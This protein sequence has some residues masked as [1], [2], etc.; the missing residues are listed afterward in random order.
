MHML[1]DWRRFTSHRQLSDVQLRD[2]FDLETPLLNLSPHDL[3]TIRHACEGTQIFGTIG[4]GKTSGSGAAIARAYLKSGF[5]G[6][7]LCAKPEERRLWERYAS[8]TG[9]TD[10]LIIVAPN[11]P[12]RFN[13]L[14]Y[15]MRRDGGGGGITENIVA[16]LAFVIEIIEGKQDM[17]SREPFWDRAMREMLRNAV[18]LL[19]LAQGSISLQ[20]IYDVIIS[21]PQNVKQMAD[22]EWEQHSFCAQCFLQAEARQKNRRQHHDFEVVKRYWIHNFATMAPRMRS[23]IVATFTS[24]ADVLDHGMVWELLSTDITFVPELTYRSGKI[25]VLDF[26]IQEYHDLGRIIQG[27]IKLMFQRAIL[28]RETDIH[29]RPVFL[30]ADEAVNFISSFDYQYQAVA[31]SARACT[32]YLTQN[33]S[34]YYAM[35]GNHHKVDALLDNFST[36]IFHS[37]MGET[38]RYA[39]EII[40]KGWTI[41]KN[42]STSRGEN[43]ELSQSAGGSQTIESKVLPSEFSRLKNGGPSN[44]LQVD[45]ILVKNGLPWKATDEIWLPVTFTQK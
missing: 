20:N 40:S 14:D 24:I 45:A 26:P 27:I 37:N 36:K 17:D 8:E 44:R 42:Y 25:I 18:D 32:V 4:S 19:A 31:R 30:W 33:I 9:R 22:K 7:V 34:N 39:S 21:A 2:P 41:V 35:L 38:N 12:W 5:G 6:L 13:F 43:L 1:K 11:A 16:L 23:S 15:E 29:P 28:G 10:D 3:W